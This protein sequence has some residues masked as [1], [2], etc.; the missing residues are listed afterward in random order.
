MAQEVGGEVSQRFDVASTH[1]LTQLSGT[2]ST[3]RA[4]ATSEIGAMAPSPPD[5]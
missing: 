3:L 2:S 4:Q 1:A 5:K